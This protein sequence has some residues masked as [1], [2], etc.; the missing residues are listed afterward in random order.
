MFHFN[1]NKMRR[2]TDKIIKTQT[3]IEN[4][5]FGDFDR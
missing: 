2:K 4:Y 5:N 3:L 1:C